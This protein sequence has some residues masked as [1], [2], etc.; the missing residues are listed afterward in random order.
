MFNEDEEPQVITKP[1][2]RLTEYSGGDIMA[3]CG[4]QCNYLHAIHKKFDKIAPYSSIEVPEKTR[5]IS[6]ILVITA[7]KEETS[8]FL[9]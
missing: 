5:R 8:C 6:N 3:F 9:L 7:E 2:L 1:Y 4:E